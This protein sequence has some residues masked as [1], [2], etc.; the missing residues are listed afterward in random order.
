MPGLLQV[1][2]SKLFHNSQTLTFLIATFIVELCVSKTLV[3]TFCR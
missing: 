1:S 3:P 2:A